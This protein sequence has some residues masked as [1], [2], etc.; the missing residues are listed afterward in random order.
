L[1][2]I[3][4]VFEEAVELVYVFHGYLEA[5]V[6]EQHVLHAALEVFIRPLQEAVEFVD[7][8]EQDVCY[9]GDGL[10]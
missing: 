1:S 2:A 8:L 4:A 3:R 10:F 5:L 6:S 7:M 9:V